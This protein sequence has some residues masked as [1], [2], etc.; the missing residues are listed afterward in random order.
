[1]HFFAL[2]AEDVALQRLK[3]REE[4]GD[5]LASDAMKKITHNYHQVTIRCLEKEEQISCTRSLSARVIYAITHT[6]PT[7]HSCYEVP[8][9]STEFRV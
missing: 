2:R 4:L 1:M 7:T 3:A 8:G 9:Y 5:P 6:Q